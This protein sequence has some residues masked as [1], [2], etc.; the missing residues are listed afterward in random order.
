MGLFYSR[1]EAVGYD[2][3]LEDGGKSVLNSS[4][5][6]TDPY[7]LRKVGDISMYDNIRG[8]GICTPEKKVLNT[9]SFTNSPDLSEV[10]NDISLSSGSH[11]AG[12][13]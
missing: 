2:K 12:L 9:T 5:T 7:Q 3:I 8:E 13:A 10:H 4:Y 6:E 1:E 11:A